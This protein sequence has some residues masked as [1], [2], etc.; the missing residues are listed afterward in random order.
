MKKALIG[1]WCCSFLLLASCITL[2]SASTP[3]LGTCDSL[4]T[5]SSMDNLDEVDTQKSYPIRFPA[6]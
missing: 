5:L 3:H 1:L 4:A 2:L 6:L